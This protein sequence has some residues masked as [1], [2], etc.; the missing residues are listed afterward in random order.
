M[1]LSLWHGLMVTQS[2]NRIA[3]IEASENPLK[4][5]WKLP[6]LIDPMTEALTNFGSFKSNFCTTKL[7]Y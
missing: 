7:F 5:S 3:T 1:H 6:V 2:T 4:I